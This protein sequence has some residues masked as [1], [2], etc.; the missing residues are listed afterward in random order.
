MEERKSKF[1]EQIWESIGK[2]FDEYPK[3]LVTEFF[4]YWT[5]VNLNGRK[6]RFEKEKTFSINRRLATFKK[7][8]K[9]WNPEL[10]GG[11]SINYSDVA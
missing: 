8:A 6:M 11:E 7:N 3:A 10:L 5:E 2:T 9:K 4:E 1:K